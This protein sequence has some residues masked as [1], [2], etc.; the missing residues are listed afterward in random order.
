MQ[1]NLQVLAVPGHFRLY[2]LNCCVFVWMVAMVEG[3]VELLK[4]Y[5]FEHGCGAHCSARCRLRKRSSDPFAR[6]CE[7]PA[8]SSQKVPVAVIGNA[9]VSLNGDLGRQISKHRNRIAITFIKVRE[10]EQVNVPNK[11]A[12]GISAG[13]SCLQGSN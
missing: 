2:H 3:S 1:K 7:A 6:S 11:V 10:P 12:K 5:L 4:K 8:P 9:P 13:L